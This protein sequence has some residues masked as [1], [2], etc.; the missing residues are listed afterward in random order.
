[1]SITMRTAALSKLSAA[2]L[3][4]AVAML[5]S[6]GNA[7]DTV[8]GTAVNDGANDAL[9]EI[10]VTAE[11][12]EENLQKTPVA[13]TV[14]SADTLRSQNVSTFADIARTVPGLSISSASTTAPGSALPVVYIRGIGQQDPSIFQ[15]PGVGI[16]VDG[17]Y[18]ARSAGASIDLPDI[19]RVE[20]LRGPQGTLFGK[21]AVGGALNI[22]TQAPSKTPEASLD[23]SVGNYR[24]KDL[25]GFFSG[26]LAGNWQGS[27]AFNIRRE[28]GYENRLSYPTRQDLGTQG[29][30]KHQAARGRLRWEPTDD[31]TVDLSADYT[32]YRDESAAGIATVYPPTKIYSLWN[33]LVGIPAGLP[34]TPANTETGGRYS[35]FA[36][37]PNYANDD[38]W[39][40]SVAVTW[41]LAAL[42]LKSITAY[43]HVEETYSR[44]SDGSPTPFF[45]AIGSHTLGQVTQELQLLGDAFEKKLDY[46][47]GLYFLRETGSQSDLAIIAPGL[48]TATHNQSL[49][50]G[51]L[52]GVDVA[53]NSYAGF[54]QTTYHIT[55][56]LST[57]LGLRY[58]SENKSD[59]VS[60]FGTESGILY[61]APTALSKTFGALTPKFGLSYQANEDVLIYASATEGFKSGGF[62][63]R[64]SRPAGLTTFEPEKVWSYE[65]GIK[66]TLLDQRLR[67][68]F[69]SYYMTYRDIQ[70]AYFILTPQGVVNAVA[71]VAAAHVDGLEGEVTA[72]P[73]PGLEIGLSAARNYNN[74]TEIQPG[75]QVSAG[76]KLPYSPAWTASAYL[77]YKIQIPGGSTLTPHADYSYKSSTFSVIN[78]SP[79]SLL[80]QYSLLN[81][82][83][84]YQLPNGHWSIAAF[85]TNLT[86]R[87]YFVSAQDNT[88]ASLLYQLLG[89]PREY[90]VDVHVT[91]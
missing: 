81:A 23:A 77:Q 53:T 25:S 55:D 75:A 79:P 54:G 4:A 61:V 13:V 59:V 57:T 87:Y 65:L 76:D 40:T 70:L 42:T 12:R 85:G 36:T 22:V 83:L 8:A 49:E 30:E 24:L 60:S 45:S 31:V 17:V 14:L 2:L 89:R 46:I 33:T 29:G 80:P 32:R 78:N 9:G 67:V 72:L 10:T 43:R 64:V 37:G 20:V 91:F 58:T 35:T 15:D 21:N 84:T 28:D 90:G 74:Y 27:F 19:G 26:P 63:G 66:S 34:W 48:Y 69:A 38:I 7:A 86:N 52:Y 88:S 50:L 41:R 5:P 51:R 68:N 16:Y 11:R 1:M 56:A 44:D 73:L 18:V 71:N 82:R 62:N 39:G 3:L 47:A 6:I